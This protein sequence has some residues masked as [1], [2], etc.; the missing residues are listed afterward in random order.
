[1]TYGWKA[2]SIFW[3]L[4]SVSFSVANVLDILIGSLPPYRYILSRSVFCRAL[5][6][7]LCGIT[8]H[9]LSEIVKFLYQLQ[10]VAIVCG[11]QRLQRI[12]LPLLKVNIGQINETD[13]FIIADVHSYFRDIS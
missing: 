11:D 13:F 6:R 7:L 2:L 3:F 8:K 5:R 1:M 12:V 9:R 4:V 10:I